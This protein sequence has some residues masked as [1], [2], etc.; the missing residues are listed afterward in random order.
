MPTSY[1]ANK[2]TGAVGPEK[3]FDLDA[4]T[5]WRDGEFADA[6]GT[7]GESILTVTVGRVP[8]TYEFITFEKKKERDPLAW[9]VAVQNVC[10]GFSPLVSEDFTS[11]E[12][13][14]PGRASSYGTFLIDVA[15]VAAPAWLRHMRC[16]A[17]AYAPAGRLVATPPRARI[18][19]T[20]H[21]L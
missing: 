16:D 12:S 13:D 9:I 20:S 4:G 18:H 5:Q 7:D 19:M 11:S 1:T 6:A 15:S 17:P 8:A 10:G 21:R 2:A 14:F 3:L